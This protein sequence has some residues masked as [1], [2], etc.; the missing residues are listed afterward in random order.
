MKEANMKICK[1]C[2]NEY[3]H[4][5]HIRYCSVKCALYSRAVC[6]NDCKKIKTNI[7]FDGQTLS[8]KQAVSLF[9]TGSIFFSSYE[10]TCDTIHCIVPEHVNI[11][12]SKDTNNPYISLVNLYEK[13]RLPLK[14]CKHCKIV[15]IERIH[16]YCSL[17]CTFEAH[18]KKIGDCFVI[19]TSVPISYRGVPMR[20]FTIA[21][22]LKTNQ[23]IDGNIL[24]RSCGTSKCYAPD[25]IFICEKKKKRFEACKKRNMKMFD[26]IERDP[27]EELKI[28]LSQRI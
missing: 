28:F 1:Y 9:K 24:D 6:I 12:I 25:H 7:N 19:T 5:Q 22:L 2:N 14:K 23:V 13:L 10:R 27:Q 8:P 11:I 20:P 17:Q 26:N 16:K 21:S 18:A 15:E 4:F 3:N